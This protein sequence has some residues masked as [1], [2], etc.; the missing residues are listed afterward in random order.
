VIL[1]RSGLDLD[2]RS[3]GSKLFGS[4][5]LAAGQKALANEG[6]ETRKAQPFMFSFPSEKRKN[7]AYL[8]MGDS[9]WSDP[10]SFDAIGSTYAVTLPSKSKQSEMHIG[11]SIEEGEGKV[12]TCS[13]YLDGA[14]I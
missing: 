6:S 14:N 1:N 7:R 5:T 9:E 13:S 3:E 8:K 11:V 4:S 10:Q 12:R 2:V